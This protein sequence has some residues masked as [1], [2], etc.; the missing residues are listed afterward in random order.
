MTECRVD[1]ND[2]SVTAERC[3]MIQEKNNAKCVTF[4]LSSAR[5]NF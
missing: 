4:C 5:K 3:K 2:N 1:W